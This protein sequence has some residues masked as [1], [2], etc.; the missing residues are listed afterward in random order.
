MN[1]VIAIIG[2]VLV[3]GAIALIIINEYTKNDS[4]KPLVKNIKSLVA[5]LVI[6]GVALFVFGNSF[7]IIPTNQIG[8]NSMYGQISDHPAKSGFN[9]KVPFD[10]IVFEL[11]ITPS[12]APFGV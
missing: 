9:F 1:V 8:V 6:A 12:F 2:A 10:S 4:A 3:V 5:G 11:I 7:K